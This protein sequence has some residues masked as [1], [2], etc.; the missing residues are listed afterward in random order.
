MEKHEVK[1]TLLSSLLKSDSISDTGDSGILFC[2]LPR[3]VGFLSPS[4]LFALET[5]GLAGCFSVTLFG[6]AAY[7]YNHTSLRFRLSD[8]K[9]GEK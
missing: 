1:N 8:I 4:L 7:H 9:I 2:S 3:S 5:S 6:L